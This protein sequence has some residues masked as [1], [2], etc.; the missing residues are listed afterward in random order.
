MTGVRARTWFSALVVL[1]LVACAGPSVQPGP[2]GTP[3]PSGVP[4]GPVAPADEALL[5]VGEEAWVAVSVATLWRSPSSPRPVDEPALALPARVDEWLAGMTVEERRGLSGRADS[6]VLLGDR[7]RV[8]ELTEEWARVRVPD[9]PTPEA[10]GGYRGW[11]PRRQLTAR[12]P[13]RSPQWVTVTAPSAWL[14]SADAVAGKVLR[15]SF[16]TRLPFVDEDGDYLRVVAPSGR[17][18]L[19]PERRAVV[20]DRGDPALPPTRRG[21]LRSARRFVGLDYL[22]AGRSGFGFDCSGYTSLLYRARGVV[23]PRDAAPQ[24][25]T[26]TVVTGSLARGDLLFFATDGRVHHV[27]IYAGNGEMIHSPGTG[28]TVEVIS[29]TAPEYQDEYV[30]ARRFLD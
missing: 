25:E 17:H 13:K 14:R 16:G 22:W 19:V 23:L 3:P 24:S 8:V 15:V 5:A 30:G 6:Q 7:V 29:M 12:A 21:L 28:R 2:A 11:L 1:G 27:A 10:R 9:Q 18:L 20:H 4:S 26:G